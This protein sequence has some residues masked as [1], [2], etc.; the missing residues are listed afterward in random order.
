MFGKLLFIAG[1]VS[2]GLLLL[3]LNLTTPSSAGA[4]GIFAIFL[5]GYIVVMVVTTYCLWFLTKLLVRV[6]S[7]MAPLHRTNQAMPLRRAYYYASVIALAPVIIVSLQS[8][9]SIGL[10][11]VVLV[12]LFVA[13]G[14]LYVAKRIR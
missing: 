4:F 1:L 6:S 3:L 7:R 10:Y 8:V 2:A 14:C 9:G 11:E 5:L 12:I 13:L